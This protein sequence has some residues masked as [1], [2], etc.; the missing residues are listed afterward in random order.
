MILD[1]FGFN[2]RDPEHSRALTPVGFE[3]LAC[4][5]MVMATFL[6]P[7]GSAYPLCVI[8]A[9]ESSCQECG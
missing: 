7:C 2:Q 1:V 9:L 6:V 8:F 5:D 4:V 3:A